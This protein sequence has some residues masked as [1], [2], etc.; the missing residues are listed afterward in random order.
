MSTRAEARPH[1]AFPAR[2]SPRPIIGTSLVAA[3]AGLVI[4]VVGLA[5]NP[6]RAWFAYLG[7]WTVGVT[8]CVGALIL[9]MVGHAAKAGWTVVTRRLTEAVVDCLPLQ[10]LLF[11]PIVLGLRWIYPWATDPSR[12]EPAARDA[13][14]HKQGYLNPSFF[15]VRSIAYLAIFVVLGILLR[16][17]SLELDRA[18]RMALV[19]RLRTLSAGG[20]PL[21]ALALTWASFDWLMSLQP[22]WSSTIFGLYVF[23]G[24]FVA[25]IALVAVMLPLSRRRLAPPAEVTP[26]HVSAV[27]R[28]FFAMVIFWAYMAFSQLLIQWIANEPDETSFY[29]ARAHGFWTAINVVLVVGHFFVP[30]L[31]LL[32]RR[33]KRRAEVLAGVGA[34]LLVMH[35]VDVEWLVLP[36]YAAHG[37]ALPSW[38]DL[39]ALALVGGLSCAWI[40]HRYLAAPPIPVHDPQI[41]AG[42]EYESK[43]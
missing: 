40:V 26:D 11:A 19:R 14:L 37:R 7:A 39:G 34:W 17:F 2:I 33:L 12:L 10:F 41:V 23:A 29:R 5:V 36:A 22:E 3:A 24:G 25:A 20:L 28:L 30:F 38:V 21:V 43:P 32:N 15:S 9:L 13:V 16:R 4:F 8:V 31:V 27:G 18:P 1:L 6:R 35:V 42:L